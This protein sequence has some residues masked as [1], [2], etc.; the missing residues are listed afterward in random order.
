MIS[1]RLGSTV[2]E[3]SD[4]LVV[5]VRAGQDPAATAVAP[6]PEEIDAEMAAFLADAGHLAKP[7]QVEVLKRPLRR[8]AKVIFAGVGSGDEAAWRLAG[9]AISRAAARHEKVSVLV[10]PDFAPEALR[11]LAEGLWLAEYSYR[12]R[13]AKP[14]EVR[15]LETVHVLCDATHER[16]HVLLTAQVVTDATNFAR[17][18]TNTPSLIKTPEWFAQQVI[19]RADGVPGIGINVR[20]PGQLAD[21]GFG[22]I[23]AVGGG[24]AHGPRLLEMTWN[25]PGAAEHIVLAGKGITYDTGG[26]DIKP[27]E[28]M[29]LMRKDMSG[30]AAVASVAIAAARLNLPIRIT[31]L[32]PLAENM[33]SGSS[34]RSG[35]VVRH[36]GGLTSEVHNTDAEG[37]VVLADVL[38]YAVAEL[39]PDLLIDISTL[40]GAGRVAL[41]SKIAS[42][43]AASDLLAKALSD[44]AASAGESV[45]RMPLADEYVKDVLADLGDF[46]NAAGNPGSITAALYLREFVGPAREKWA[47]FD[48]S[49][50][51]WSAADDGELV[52]GATGWGV[53]TILRWLMARANS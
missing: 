25:P 45:W 48:L 38:A 14:E 31:A 50:P 37:R 32:A 18:L 46:N 26:I 17:D 7:G 27:P 33:V 36:Y 4:V 21:E 6:V 35:D 30:A 29:L 52:K 22:G 24:S 11:G 20:D 3:Q 28:Y 47:H 43:F 49:A 16:M 13:E 53:R 51:A 9:A 40:T 10:A 2:A 19:E 34:W 15:S 44:A 42:L 41:G 1:I 39:D 8:P 5:P 23:L 12:L